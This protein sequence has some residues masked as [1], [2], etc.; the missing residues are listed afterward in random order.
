MAVRVLERLQAATLARARQDALA[1]LRAAAVEPPALDEMATFPQWVALGESRQ[2]AVVYDL[3]FVAADLLIRRHGV[4]AV[5]RYFARFAESQDR[6][7]NFEA[8]FSEDLRTF[9]AALR[10]ELWPR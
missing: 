7:A 1:N 4:P 6:A 2:Q 9:E 10:K 3:A 8:A 5:L